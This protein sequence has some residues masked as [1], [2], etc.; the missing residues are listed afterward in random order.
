MITRELRRQGTSEEPELSVRR[1]S[2]PLPESFKKATRDAADK[3]V[4]DHIKRGIG[5][6]RVLSDEAVA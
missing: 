6:R 2:Q 4:R 3:L 1:W 5:K